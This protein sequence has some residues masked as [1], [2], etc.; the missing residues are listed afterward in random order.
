MDFNFET[1]TIINV[2]LHE[3]IIFNYEYTYNVYGYYTVHTVKII[4]PT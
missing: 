4:I 1:W 2:L 3:C